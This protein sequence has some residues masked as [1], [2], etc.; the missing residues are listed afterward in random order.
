MTFKQ[1]VL[2]G[3]IPHHHTP[4]ACFT[5]FFCQLCLPSLTIQQPTSDKCFII[6]T[7][8]PTS[9]HPSTW[10]GGHCERWKRGEEAFCCIFY[11]C[12]E[13]K[14]PFVLDD[15]NTNEASAGL[16]GKVSI[17]SIHSMHTARIWFM[18]TFIYTPFTL[19]YFAF[20]S[21]LCLK[22]AATK[23]NVHAGYFTV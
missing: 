20:P 9:P 10:R 21:N 23:G 5:S 6:D 11:S 8:P 14:Q 1:L 19:V 17:Y 16:E 2:E 18:G 4:L 3:V 12:S 15:W 7:L 22:T 13:D